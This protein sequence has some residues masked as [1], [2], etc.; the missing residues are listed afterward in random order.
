MPQSNCEGGQ[1]GCYHTHNQQF[2]NETFQLSSNCSVEE[3]NSST[4]QFGIIQKNL[5]SHP[6]PS[7]WK[8]QGDFQGE[9]TSPYILVCDEMLY[10]QKR[11]MRIKYWEY[12]ELFYGQFEVLCHKI[13]FTQKIIVKGKI[14]G[15][16]LKVSFLYWKTAFPYWLISN[17][18]CYFSPNQVSDIL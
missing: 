12:A 15:P 18:T 17:P 8:I 16:R 10:C 14:K 6:I 7:L 4:L 5:T 1:G 13:I 2:S 11:H 9:R 3:Q